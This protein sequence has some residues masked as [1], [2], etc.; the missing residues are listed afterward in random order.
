[1]TSKKKWRPPV[2]RPKVEP[3]KLH[4]RNITASFVVTMVIL[5]ITALILSNRSNNLDSLS[6][7]SL[8]PYE[9]ADPAAGAVAP[10]FTL[11]STQGGVVSLSDY[12][13]K[14]VLLFFHEG[15]G[16]QPCWDQIRDLEKDQIKLKSAGI[17]QLL[18]ITSGPT[19]LIAQKMN[20]D[21]LTAIA[22]GDTNLEVSKIYNA[23]KY[24]MMG[25]SRNGHSFILVGPDGMIDWR[26]DYGGPP[27]Y[28]MYVPVKNLLEDMKTERIP[29]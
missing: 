26:A 11:P 2:S 17:D 3:K 9:V 14:T 4:Q 25:D 13:G 5:L 1:M 24:G 19:R 28:T 21:G 27:K 10:D 15:I 7:R 16:C 8:F 29:S 20:D 22:L 18:T 12:V 23:N 6:N